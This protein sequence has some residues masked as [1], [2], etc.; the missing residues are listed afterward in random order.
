MAWEAA[1]VSEGNVLTTELNALAAG[2]RTNAGT[3]IRND[4]NFDQIG[5]LEINVTFASAPAA[6]DYL[7][8]HMVQAP[9][10]T[11][12]EDGS[13]TVD[14]GPH[15]LKASVQVRAVATAQ[16]LMTRIFQLEPGKTKFILVN[17]NATQAFPATGSTVELFSTNDG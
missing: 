17:R 13:S 15:T 2:S 6:G 3:E 1:W 12:Y 8:I 16:R 14:P 9:D 11:N 4:V 7:D 10:G 5:K